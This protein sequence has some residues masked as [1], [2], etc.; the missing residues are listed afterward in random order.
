V[1]EA[2]PNPAVAFQQIALNGS[3]SFHQD[4]G[5]VI[6]SWEWDLDNDG[7]YD[8]ASGPTTTTSFPAVGD[9]PVGL[10]VTDNDSPE[11]S[12]TTTLIVRITTPPIA[13][14]AQADGPY[15]LC[16]QVQPWFLDG[17]GSINPDE[18]QSEPGRPGDTIQSYEWELDGDGD[19]DDA[20]GAQPDVTAFFQAS[21]V[22]DY[23]VQLR[24]KDTTST[25]FP[26]SG[27][28]DLTDTDAAQV[29]VK[30]AADQICNCV[31]DLATTR[32]KDG[33]VQLNWTPIGTPSY[34]VYRGTVSGG[35][36]LLVGNTTSQLSVFVDYGLTNGTT[37]YYVVRP[38]S[39]PAPGSGSETCQSNQTS[40]TPTGRVRR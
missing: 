35:P 28:P 26:S 13:P 17:T 19:F 38:Y 6:D 20:L 22:G 15:V 9:Y 24:V 21:G 30:D 25:S 7:A 29:S 39:S 12:D 2:V 4:T 14:T 5:F 37:Y 36:Y 27:Q 32:A 16:P 11:K 34:N 23:L 8:D 18:G 1:A 10:R 3:G 33:K 31:D 40:A